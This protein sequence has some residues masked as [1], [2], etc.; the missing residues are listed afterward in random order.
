M[1]RTIP[2]GWQELEIKDFLKFTPRG[3]DKPKV[4]YRSLGI[5][6]HCK[7]TFV[8]EVENP[9]KVMM[10]TLYAVKKDD[11]IVNITFAWEGAVALV[12]KS[13]EGALVSHRFPTYVFDRSVVVPEFFRYLIPS[14]R[15][16]YSLGIISPG[17]AGRNRVL[18]RKDFLHL[19]FIMPPAEEQKLIANFISTW[20]QAID[21]LGK[22]IKSKTCRFNGLIDLLTSPNRKCC[23]WEE[24]S[25]GKLGDIIKGKGI[26]KNDLTETGI[27]CIR[28]ADLY[29]QYDFVI[30]KINSFIS[31]KAVATSHV[32]K[33]GDI[34][35]AGSGE[36]AEDIGK[37]AVYLGE[38]RSA[39][40]GGDTLILKQTICDPNY[41]AYALNSPA[42]NKQKSV[43]GHGHSVVHLYGKDLKK[44]RLFLPSVEYQ[45]KYATILNSAKQ[46]IDL[47]KSLMQCYCDQKMGIIQKLLTG[48]IRVKGVTQ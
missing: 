44:V 14:K 21:T 16:V 6:S 3:V 24:T 42:V 20:D 9:D 22:L 15:L 17:G 37:C 25:I 48:K 33:Y 13:D 29:T 34:L 26:T 12:N 41:L 19:Q 18:D 40:V 7:G 43:F 35:F 11:L 28:Y 27:P 32:L 4:K 45:K 36:T 47:L 38:Y 10:D 30:R 23:D 31:S 1:A 39:V 5:R 46:E 8:R 2:R